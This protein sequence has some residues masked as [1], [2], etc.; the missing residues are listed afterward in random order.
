MPD[1]KL[2]LVCENPGNGI[3]IFVHGFGRLKGEDLSGYLRLLREVNLKGRTYLFDWN[4]GLL[5]RPIIPVALMAGGILGVALY[6]RF[7]GKKPASTGSVPGAGFLKKIIGFGASTLPVFPVAASIE[8]NIS[9]RKA[10]ALGR[11]FQAI[12]SVIPRIKEEPL[13]LIGFS[14]GARLLH[15]ALCAHS[16]K[17]YHVKDVCFLGGA[18]DAHS[19]DW[20]DCVSKI[21]G[22]LYNF[23]SR[24]DDA[25]AVKPDGEKSIGRHPIPLEISKVVNIETVLH[26]HRHPSYNENLKDLLQ[27]LGPLPEAGQTA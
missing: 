14:L 23:Y 2:D 9:K 8:F 1:A 20:G 7:K 17:E 22:Y 25:L 10:D 6:R 19:H 24:N 12:I 18:A 27:V 21:S 15:T 5:W 11:D 26:H 4:S 13:N 3:N 16:W